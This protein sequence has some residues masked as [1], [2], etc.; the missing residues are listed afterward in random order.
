MHKAATRDCGIISI[1]FACLSSVSGLE[2][3]IARV[4]TFPVRSMLDCGLNQPVSYG[5]YRAF[6]KNLKR[7]ITSSLTFIQ[8]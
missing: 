4:L 3:S 6:L 5:T 7:S 8:T 2:K 1:R